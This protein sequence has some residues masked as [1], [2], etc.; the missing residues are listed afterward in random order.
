MG[1]W[2][3]VSRIVSMLGTGSISC[4]GMLVGWSRIS[5]GLDRVDDL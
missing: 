5:S 1:C 4:K 2:L 3:D